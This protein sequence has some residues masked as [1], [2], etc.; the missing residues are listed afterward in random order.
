MNGQLWLIW[1]SSIQLS[2]KFYIRQDLY[3]VFYKHMERSPLVLFEDRI[4]PG[5]RGTFTTI[6]TMHPHKNSF[7]HQ[8]FDSKW[9]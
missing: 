3:I 4:S 5:D 2:D 6:D 9:Y 7:I 1:D 8:E